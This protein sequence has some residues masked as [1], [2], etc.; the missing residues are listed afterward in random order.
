MDTLAQA[1]AKAAAQRNDDDVSRTIVAFVH[2]GMWPFNTGRVTL[3][4]EYD[5]DYLNHTL[6]VQSERYMWM[7]FN[8]KI[9]DRQ[10]YQAYQP[11][12]FLIEAVRT[13]LI[14]HFR[15]RPSVEPD[16]H[17]VLGED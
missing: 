4:L 8:Y 10:M 5:M 3:W 15:Y 1:L 12:L 7:P 9:D 13:P 6:W 11:E 2:E 16:D 17:I 14:K